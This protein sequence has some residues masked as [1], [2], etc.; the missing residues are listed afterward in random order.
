MVD[1]VSIAASSARFVAIEHGGAAFLDDVFRPAHCVSRVDVEDVANH[2]PIEQHPQ[3]GEMSLDGRLR[4][5]ALQFFDVGGHVQWP[6]L[7]QV[8]Q[9]PAFAPLTEAT[10]G[11]VVGASGVPVAI[12]AVKN[13]KKRSVAFALGRNTS[14]ALAIAAKPLGA[15]KGMISPA[16]LMLSSPRRAGHSP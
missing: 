9:S 15:L 2:E 13:S 8:A 5:L 4:E 16:A 12:L 3:R 10:H 6:A 14:G 7:G 11:F 1:L